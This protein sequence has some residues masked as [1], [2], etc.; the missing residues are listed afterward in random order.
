M[1]WEDKSGEIHWH[2]SEYEGLLKTISDLK[3]EIANLKQ[4]LNT[5]K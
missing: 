3:Q 5:G 4:M 1:I 2:K